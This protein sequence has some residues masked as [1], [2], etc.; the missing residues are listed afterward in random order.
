MTGTRRDGSV[1]SATTSSRG[2]RSTGGPGNCATAWSATR[3]SRTSRKSSSCGSRRSQAS[4]QAERPPRFKRRSEMSTNMRLLPALAA[5]ALL[6]S[7]GALLGRGGGGGGFP[8]RRRLLQRRRRHT[9]AEGVSAAVSPRRISRRRDRGGEYRGGDVSAWCG[10]VHM[11]PSG[12]RATNGT[13]TT[14]AR[15]R[16]PGRTSTPIGNR[17]NDRSSRLIRIP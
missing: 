1:A 3:C 9:A 2:S 15:R 12:Q 10:D 13:K 14:S 11:A 8:R 17:Q 5:I 6:A 7:D 16:P 4:P